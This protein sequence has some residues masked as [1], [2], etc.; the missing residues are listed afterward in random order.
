MLFAGVLSVALL[1]L[2]H[3]AEIV[4]KDGNILLIVD[5]TDQVVSIATRS[6]YTNDGITAMH[7]AVTMGQV[8]TMMDA[9]K[10]ELQGAIDNVTT[11][12]TGYETRIQELEEQNIQ[13]ASTLTT[14][15]NTK[16]ASDDVPT[17]SDIQTVVNGM[18]TPT[19][20]NALKSAL[21][22]KV[23]KENQYDNDAVRT[24]LATIINANPAD[25]SALR[26]TLD[27]LAGRV[28]SIESELD[29]QCGDAVCTAGSFVKTACD[30]DAGVD[31]VCETCADNTYS[32]GGLVS[33]CLTCD[34]CASGFHEVGACTSVSNRVC[35]KCQQCVPGVTYETDPCTSTQ[36]R[37]CSVCD[38]CDADKW[39]ETPCSL[40]A[41]TKCTKCT[42]CTGDLELLTPCS[43]TTD[44]VCQPRRAG[45]LADLKANLALTTKGAWIPITGFATDDDKGGTFVRPGTN[46][47]GSKFTITRQ[48]YYLVGF[49]VRVDQMSGGYFHVNLL[50]NAATNSRDQ[51]LSTLRG[52]SNYG[53]WTFSTAGVVK[54]AA[55]TTYAVN[56]FAETDTSYRIHSFSGFTGFELFP[57]EGVY[58]LPSGNTRIRN[59][60]YARVGRWTTDDD[61]SFLI[62]GTF[63]GG[64]GDYTVQE[65]GI[66]I[67]SLNVRFNNV[68]TQAGSFV[69]AFIDINDK[70][71]INAGL[72]SIQ[73]QPHPSDFFTVHTQGAAKLKK[74][75]VIAPKVQSNKDDDYTI[76]A[77]SH[78]SAV[79]L[80]TSY[81]F[82]ADLATNV[83]LTRNTVGPINRNWRTTDAQGLFDEGNVFDENTGVFT[84]PVSGWYYASANVRLDGVGAVT[85]M[86]AS[87]RS[88]ADTTLKDHGIYAVQSPIAGQSGSAQNTLNPVGVTYVP[89][90]ASLDIWVR[91]QTSSGSPMVQSTTGFSVILLHE[92]VS[93]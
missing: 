56:V 35:A 27:T 17:T 3:A 58:A 71:E 40:T 60:N 45:F 5:S 81:G 72:H 8:K 84:A 14:L 30:P 18:V 19:A 73:G 24:L 12:L 33:S 37:S 1:A 23:D 4:T 62:G 41:N 10:A 77:Q 47:D 25:A 26:T 48:G 22:Q 65:D 16:A 34:T 75:D 85:Y 57:E 67:L 44:T 42:E 28:T 69:R 49:N 74:G 89:K 61:Q 66:F 55:S 79:R 93:A 31:R 32:F 90:G 46:F 36:D 50:R 78:F 13:Q 70:N 92:D 59:T 39:L 20:S 54:A 2:T 43:A 21:N 51:G 87:I 91:V 9:M 83:G 38:S 15:E 6:E 11:D 53:V 52:S 86:E 88:S 68:A 64:T 29:A 80:N 76:Y 82:C 63:K 7:Q